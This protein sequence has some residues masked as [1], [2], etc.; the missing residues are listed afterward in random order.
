MGNFLV[1]VNP[2]ERWAEARGCFQAGVADARRLKRQAPNS[3]AETPW[4][5]AASFP[6]HNGSGAPVFTDPETGSWALSVGTW[7]HASCRDEAGLLRRYLEAGPAQLALELEGFFTIVVGDARRREVVVITDVAG[8]CHCFVR[9]LNSGVALSSSSRLLAGLETCSLDPVACQ[10][11]LHTGI[12][13]EDRTIYR[14]VRKLG[15]AGVFR[16]RSGAAREQSRYWN[17]SALA[18]ESLAGEAAVERLWSVLTSAAEKVTRRFPHPVCDLTGGYDSRALVSAFFANGRN[19]STTVSGADDSPDVLVSRGLARLMG[20]P[21]RQFPPQS[22]GRLADLQAAAELTDGEYDVVEYAR[23]LAVHQELSAGFDASINGSFGEVA[24]GY[25]WEILVPGTGRRGKLD[26]AKL[27]RLRY[28]PRS[29]SASLFDPALRLDLVSHF[30]GIVERANAGLFATPNTFQIDNAYLAMRMQRW[31][32]RIAS[33]T[34]QL[35]PCLSPFMFRSALEAMLQAR[36]GLRK[37]SLLIRRMLARFQPQLARYPL[38][39]GYPALPATWKTLP[40]FWPLAGYYG[41]KVRQRAGLG[42]THGHRPDAAASVRLRLWQ[43]PSTQELLDP[44][45][46]KAAELF[47]GPA[48]AAFLARSRQANFPA[49]KEWSR[50]LSLEYAL[51]LPAGA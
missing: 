2:E 32:G 42:A 28:V 7:F 50:L 19:F 35:W 34:N 37:R 4:S 17:L 16:F 24:R 8:S 18:P 15:P 40:R 47:D 25:W 22:P 26:P 48:L 21:H 44:A 36:A 41:G 13:Y 45:R 49:E 3:T 46:M 1:I 51:R 10:E 23:T 12:I 11:F 20:V 31:Q 30:T 38:E 39:H 29:F 27:A 6:R 9:P 5:L 14:E 33:S 43:D